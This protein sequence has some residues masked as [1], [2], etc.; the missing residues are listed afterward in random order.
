MFCH[1]CELI[2]N[3]IKYCPECGDAYIKNEQVCRYNFILFAVFLGWIGVHRLYLK[4]Y[5]VFLFY[6]LVF[7][8][9]IRLSVFIAILD[10]YLVGFNKKDKRFIY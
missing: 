7:L 9:D 8:V 10:T 1:N 4:S 6:I 5:I 3:D 2:S